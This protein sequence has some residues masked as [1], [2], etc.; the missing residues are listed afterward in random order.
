M[1]EV[2][3]IEGMG[4]M[5]KQLAIIPPHLPVPISLFPNLQRPWRRKH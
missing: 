2:G 5:E 4:D 3:E 1:R